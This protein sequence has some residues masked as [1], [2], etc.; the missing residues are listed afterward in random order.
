MT[1]Y[2]I[3]VEYDGRPFMGWQRQAHGPSVQAAIEDALGTIVT[4]TPTVYG[5][6][7]TDAGVHALGQ[8]AHFDLETGMTPFRLSE[9]LNAR[10]RPHPVAIIGCE[11][12]AKDFHARFDCKSRTY[13][14]R[15]RNRRAPL[16]LSAGR[17]WR[18]AKRLDEDAMGEAAEH[19]VGKH[20]F[21]TFRSIR[22]QA[23]SAV[24]TIGKLTVERRGDLVTIVA[25]APSF[26]H[27]QVRSIAGCLVL[28][29]DGRWTPDHMLSALDARDRT[30]LG[31]NAPPDG[32]YFLR[33]DY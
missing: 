2:R 6:G 3:T 5:C 19:L 4:E 20:D 17:E 27:H 26:L 15:I 18:V 25:R 33:A 29:G 28:V 14:Y 1:R 16:T 13:E 10:L 22:C 24:K 11:E 8:V 30:A 7:R 9:A 31:L 32:L 21:T 23:K 12:A